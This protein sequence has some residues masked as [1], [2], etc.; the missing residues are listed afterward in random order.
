MEVG[1][2][3]KLERGVPLAFVVISFFSGLEVEGWLKDTRDLWPLMRLE[4]A[5]EGGVC[6]DMES[7]AGGAVLEE[8]SLKEKFGTGPAE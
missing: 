2:L 8:G 7:V 6:G 5:G 4:G 1:G 3:A